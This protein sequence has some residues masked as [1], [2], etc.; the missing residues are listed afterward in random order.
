MSFILTPWLQA[1]LREAGLEHYMD[2]VALW[3]PL[4]QKK[5]HTTNSQCFIVAAVKVKEPDASDFWTPLNFWPHAAQ[6]LHRFY[7]KERL[8][9]KACTYTSLSLYSGM[10]L[11]V[12]NVHCLC[13]VWHASSLF[14]SSVQL[15]ATPIPRGAGFRG[16]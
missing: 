15:H 1:E 8:A 6:E 9:T 16:L 7:S 3:S 2:N 10:Q 14:Y 4:G 13:R 11:P 5:K 12:F